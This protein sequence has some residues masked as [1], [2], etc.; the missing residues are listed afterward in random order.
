MIIRDGGKLAKKYQEC[1]YGILHFDY[2]RIMS[3]KCRILQKHFV[4][5]E[6]HLPRKQAF[7]MDEALREK[8][9]GRLIWYF[10]LSNSKK[11][12]VP[13]IS[14]EEWDYIERWVNYVLEG[15]LQRLRKTH[16]NLTRND[17]RI[18]CLLRLRL[19]R[20]HIA[21]LMGISL[22]SVSTYKLRIKKKMNIRHLDCKSEQS[23]YL[24]YL[25]SI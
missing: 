15:F 17:L 3:T 1:C 7:I 4:F 16:P 5:G 13:C 11:E 8:L 10:G 9:C 24:S 2:Y 25:Y 19:S 14:Q 6:L 20:S 21:N 22:S 12:K 23:L 18:C